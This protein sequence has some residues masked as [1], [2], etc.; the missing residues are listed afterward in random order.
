MEQSKLCGNMFVRIVM[1]SPE[2]MCFLASDQQ[3]K[4]LRRF[5]TNPE[6]FCIVS[7]DPTFSPGYFS[8]IFITYRHLLVT[9][10]WTGESPVMLGPVFVHQKKAF[11]SYHIFA[12]SL[13]SLVPSLDKLLA[14][15]TDGE[16]PLLSAFRKQFKFA[17]ILHC[18]RHLRQN[19]RRKLVSDMGAKFGR[20]NPF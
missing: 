11:E 20:P 5:S 2:P 9:D 19:I 18:F 4:D 3:L 16:D 12:L 8:V 14:F 10:R 1:V 15:S 13:I 7:I 6:R 17:I